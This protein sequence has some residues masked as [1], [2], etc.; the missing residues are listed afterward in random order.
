[1]NPGLPADLDRVL[2]RC[3]AKDPADRYPNCGA[4]AAD[5]EALR[6]GRPL[7]TTQSVASE[8]PP[9]AGTA[10]LPV[11]SSPTASQQSGSTV[12]LV[13]AS[14]K[15][16]PLTPGVATSAAG[17]PPT[18]AVES[19]REGRRGWLAGSGVLLLAA[20][21]GSAWWLRT[22]VPA[23][24]SAASPP[25]AQSIFA[26]PPAAVPA[27]APEKTAAS[28][29]PS[30]AKTE[31]PARP[32][33][34]TSTLQI[35]CKHNFQSATLEIYLD[36][37]MFYRSPLHGEEQRHIV[38]HYEGR[39]STERPIASGRHTLRVRVY[40]TRDKYDDQDN[41]TGEFVEGEPRTLEI[42]FGKGSGLGMVERNINLTLR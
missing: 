2:S 19:S 28:P 12:P 8:T 9:L 17:V 10:A 24:Q 15:T 41:V 7:A 6:A 35:V 42:E 1:L 31:V 34:A 36:G 27:P 30:V 40:S 39:L 14:D 5:L 22:R 4:L 11:A 3:L 13:T 16:H 18:H 38:K 32:P 20:I 25:P 37:A 26:P 33:A 23:A 21:L 29:A